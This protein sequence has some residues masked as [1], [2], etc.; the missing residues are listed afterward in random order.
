MRQSLHKDTCSIPFLLMQIMNV[1]LRNLSLKLTGKVT[2]E[3]E[4]NTKFSIGTNQP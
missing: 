1:H 4:N 3:T 2:Q